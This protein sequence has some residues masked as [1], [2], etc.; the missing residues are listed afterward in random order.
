[1]QCPHRLPKFDR[2]GLLALITMFSRSGFCAWGFARCS[3]RVP[4]HAW[5]DAFRPACAARRQ[6]ANAPCPRSVVLHVSPHTQCPTYIYIY[7]YLPHIC[8]ARLF[9]LICWRAR[10]PPHALAFGWCTKL[11]LAYKRCLSVPPA[12]VGLSVLAH[13]HCSLLWAYMDCLTFVCLDPA[14]RTRCR[15]SGARHALRA[16]LW[17]SYPCVN[18]VAQ[19]G[20]ISC[21]APM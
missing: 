3:T 17:S 2:L 8:F 16:I 11:P 4:L 7:I 13:A 14:L 1:M 9:P 15:T 6:L 10:T 5:P 18:A 19:I 12:H 20:F 21:V